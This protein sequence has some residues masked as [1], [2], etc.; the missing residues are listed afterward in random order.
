[1]PSIE[2]T[3]AQCREQRAHAH[4]PA[5][6]VL[7]GRDGLTPAVVREIDA[8]LDAHGL[9]NARVFNDDRGPREGMDQKLTA[10]LNAASIQHIGKLPV[11]WR[12]LPVKERVVDE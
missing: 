12:L 6:V 10:D 7:I 8:A 1:M 11:L 3:P 5:P 9:I 2:L 4:R